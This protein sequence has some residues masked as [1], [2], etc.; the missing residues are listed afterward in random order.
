MSRRGSGGVLSL[1]TRGK[2][3]ALLGS[4]APCM[5]KPDQERQQ[6]A[7][8]IWVAPVSHALRMTRL[9]TLRHRRWSRLVTHQKWCRIIECP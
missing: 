1:S 8:Q 5:S 7:G 9:L 6:G 2:A 3:V 4:Q